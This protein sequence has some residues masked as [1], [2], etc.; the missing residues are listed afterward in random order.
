METTITRASKPNAVFSLFHA[1]LAEHLQVEEAQFS[2][3]QAKLK[4]ERRRTRA[5]A[6]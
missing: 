2:W 5:G 1:T 3:F 6:D 4:P